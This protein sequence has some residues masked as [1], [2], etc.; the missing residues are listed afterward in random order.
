MAF[1]DSIQDIEL[2]PYKF[3]AHIDRLKTLAEGGD[4]FPVTVEMDLVDYC[5]HDCWWCVDPIHQNHS[6]ERPFVSELLMEFKALGIKGIVCKGGGEQMLHNDFSDI[7]AE[8]KSS[9]LRG[10]DWHKREPA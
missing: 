4:V 6:L 9:R 1:G 2:N 3:I 7:L 10:R 8:T 5:N